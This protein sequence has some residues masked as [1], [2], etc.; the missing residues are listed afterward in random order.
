[1]VDYKT[2]NGVERGKKGKC[3][4]SQ[5]VSWHIISHP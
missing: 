5:E 4:E 2:D 3:A 1:M